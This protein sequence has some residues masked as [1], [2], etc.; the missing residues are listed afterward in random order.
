M[1]PILIRIELMSSII[2]AIPKYIHDLLIAWALALKK[3][4]IGIF[5]VIWVH[6]YQQHKNPK[7]LRTLERVKYSDNP[8][9]LSPTVMSPKK[10]PNQD[11]IARLFWSIDNF[12][13]CNNAI[14]NYSQ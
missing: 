9:K 10:N 13:I 12:F 6:G 14:N 11:F 5:H 8:W 3:F 1:K 4:F 7:V 2:A